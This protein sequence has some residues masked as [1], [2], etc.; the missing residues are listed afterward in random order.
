MRTA[1]M[2]ACLA[3]L[4]SPVSQAF[5][6]VALPALELPFAIDGPP[7]PELPATVARDA[8][9]RITVRAIRLGAPLRI[10]GQLDEA[11]YRDVEPVSD[12]IQ[13]EPHPGG[14]ASEKTEAWISFDSDNV[15]VSVRAF[16]SQPK[17]MVLTSMRRDS[18]TTWQNECF[19]ISFDTFYDR[20]NAVTFQFTPIGG[21]ADGQFTNEAQYNG[22]CNTVWTFSVR[23][24]ERGWTGEAAIP[25]KSL[26]YRP[27]RGQIWG[28]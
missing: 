27:G 5:P 28:L 8:E 15:Y 3:L 20:R 9:G 21:W 19:G 26:R 14:T 16:E 6:Q 4:L 22:D 10:D 11:L 13:D 18:N 7:P 23:R 12:F 1:N 24:N 25:F 2:A 17:R